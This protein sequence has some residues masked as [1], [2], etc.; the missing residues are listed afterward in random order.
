MSV[1]HKYTA[2]VA[3]IAVAGQ[4]FGGGATW[5]SERNLGY[6]KFLRFSFLKLLKMHQILKT[7][8][9]TLYS[10][11]ARLLFDYKEH[12]LNADH[13]AFCGNIQLIE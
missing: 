8:Q 6:G 1:D 3:Y 2:S 5:P 13:T 11:C 7:K 10:T 4:K 9:L 12:G